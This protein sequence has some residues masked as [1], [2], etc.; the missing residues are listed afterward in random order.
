MREIDTTWDC[1]ERMRRHQPLT[2][3][4]GDV[5]DPAIPPGLK[6]HRETAEMTRDRDYIAGILIVNFII[7][8][9]NFFALCWHKCSRKRRLIFSIATEICELPVPFHAP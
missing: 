2:R 1:A 7:E 8:M 5:Q 3:P 9:P 6:T 4:A